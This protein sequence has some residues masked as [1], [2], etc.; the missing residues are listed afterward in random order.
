MHDL[1]LK[2]VCTMSDTSP[3]T[4]RSY[5]ARGLIDAARDS[6]GNWLFAATAPDAIRKIRMANTTKTKAGQINARRMAA[7]PGRP[8]R[9]A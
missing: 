2:R 3:Q 5:A 6:N 4:V 7:K 8:R 9:I 1:R